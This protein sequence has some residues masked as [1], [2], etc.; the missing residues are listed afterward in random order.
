M[1]SIRTRVLTTEVGDVRPIA[2]SLLAPDYD[3]VEKLVQHIGTTKAV[4]VRR[5]T[6]KYAQEMEERMLSA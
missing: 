2:S 5:A 1:K 3:R 4:F 6:L